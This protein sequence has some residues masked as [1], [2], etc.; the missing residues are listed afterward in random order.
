MDHIDIQ[1]I[2]NWTFGICGLLVGWVLNNLRDALRDLQTADSS[3][4]DKVQAIEV[5]VAGEYVKRSELQTLSEALFKKLDRIEI[6]IDGKM[7]RA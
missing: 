4:T 6:K 7:D 1:T 3:L 5:L 2:L